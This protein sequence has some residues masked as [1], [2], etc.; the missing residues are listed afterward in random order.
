M[1]TIMTV[2]PK[3]GEL[4]TT[5]EKDGMCFWCKTPLSKFIKTNV[6]LTDYIWSFES[7]EKYEN[8]IH[9][10]YF[11]NNPLCDMAM[12]K[13]RERKQKENMEASKAEGLRQAEEERNNIRCPE[14]GSTSLS[15]NKKGFGL[16]KAAV[17]GILTGGVG[18]LAGFI[19]SRK[20]EIT[21]LNCGHRFAAGKK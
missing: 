14:C 20:V 3:C 21:C 2:C 11:F 15:A 18:L 10:D 13:Y 8:L 9:E 19:G 5:N 17:G 16:G 7:Q 6:T 1:E 4:A 12:F